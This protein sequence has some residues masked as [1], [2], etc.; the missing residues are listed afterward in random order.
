MEKIKLLLE[1]LLKECRENPNLINDR[2]GNSTFFWFTNV[3][4][5][6]IELRVMEGGYEV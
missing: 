1:E 5:D 4:G 3:L 2:D 6:D